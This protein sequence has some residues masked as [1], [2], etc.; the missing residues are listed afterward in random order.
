MVPKPRAR[1]MQTFNI[2]A[3][4]HKIAN[5]SADK[6]AILPC[7]PPRLDIL[8]LYPSDLKPLTHT[9]KLA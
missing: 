7:T 3:D 2:S 1:H 6:P 5:L 4:E 8:Y 9:P